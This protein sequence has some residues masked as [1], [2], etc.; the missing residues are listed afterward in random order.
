VLQPVTTLGRR[1]DL[2]EV[3][4]QALVWRVLGRG[5]RRIAGELGLAPT[6]VRGWLRR[7]GV[8]AERLR[9]HFTRLAHA[10]DPALPPLE[11]G[12]T[13]AADAL[14]AIGMAA[15]AAARRL[16]PA[17]PWWFAAGATGGWLLGNT[18]APFPAPG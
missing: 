17:P 16:G 10:L 2:A 4:G 1:L 5:H 3:I 8:R 11:P 12:G 18:S 6:T 9:A 14:E 7:F 15:A 13:G